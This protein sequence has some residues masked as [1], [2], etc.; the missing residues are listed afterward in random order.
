MG[1]TVLLFSWYVDA[2]S[3]G[4]LLLP[5]GADLNNAATQAMLLPTNSLAA[6]QAIVDAAN[7]YGGG[8][9]TL[10]GDFTAADGLTLTFSGAVMGNTR[11]PAWPFNAS[12][13]TSSVTPAANYSPA[14]PTYGQTYAAASCAVWTLQP[15]IQNFPSSPPTGSTLGYQQGAVQLTFGGNTVTVNSSDNYETTAGA[16]AVATDGTW[17][18]TASLGDTYTGPI[19]LKRV[20][21]GPIGSSPWSAEQGPEPLLMDFNLPNGEWVSC[22][23]TTPGPGQISDDGAGDIGINASGA[24]G[25]D[26]SALF[27]NFWSVFVPVGP[28]PND[29]TIDDGTTYVT[30]YVNQDI[31]SSY[32]GGILSLSGGAS[33]FSNAGDALQMSGA[34][35]NT[36]LVPQFVDGAYA[37]PQ[38]DWLTAT[39]SAGSLTITTE[40]GTTAAIPWGPYANATDCCAAVQAAIIAT[41]PGNL[42]GLTVAVRSGASWSPS[43]WDFLIKLPLSEGAQTWSLDDSGLNNGTITTQSVQTSGSADSVTSIFSSPIFGDMGVMA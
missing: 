11:I 23:G 3:G 8:T 17:T 7:P 38:I 40:Y 41:S 9:I 18:A 19:T 43:S 39:A 36:S 31:S 27:A 29:I 12:S 5:L 1:S 4:S 24:S 25:T 16:V 35:A 42:S 37:Q 32:G 22:G 2:T 30:Y 13:L 10:G 34:Y 21:M 26:Y 20:A 15:T 28:G 33:P 6:N 14:D